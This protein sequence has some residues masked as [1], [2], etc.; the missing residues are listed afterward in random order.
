MTT[1]E[2]DLA[3][4]IQK[5]SKKGAALVLLLLFGRICTARLATNKLE[6]TIREFLG[7]EATLFVSSH[8]IHL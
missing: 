4:Q 2:T 1:K 5:K 7:F 6:G 8:V 3:T